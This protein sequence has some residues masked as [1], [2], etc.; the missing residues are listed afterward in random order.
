MTGK[1]NMLAA[2]NVLV[3]DIRRMID[4]ARILAASVVNAGLY[5]T[6][7]LKLKDKDRGK[8]P[9]RPKTDY[10]W[11]L[12][13]ERSPALTPSAERSSSVRAGTT[14]TSPSCEKKRQTHE[15]S[16]NMDAQGG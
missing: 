9:H 4:K 10:P 1:K 5:R 14:Y 13:E 16:I 11:F 2:D 3:H 8:E 15:K 12:C 6:V 7:P